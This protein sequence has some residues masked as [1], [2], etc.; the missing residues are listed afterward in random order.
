MND[1]LELDL[2]RATAYLQGIPLEQLLSERA[3][4]EAKRDQQPEI[5]YRNGTM[6]QDGQR[7]TDEQVAMHD[8]RNPYK[9]ENWLSDRALTS[10]QQSEDEKFQEGIRQ[11]EAARRDAMIA[12]EGQSFG[13][14]IRGSGAPVRGIKLEQ[15]SVEAIPAKTAIPYNQA[16]G[17][18][19]PLKNVIRGVA[20]RTAK[21]RKTQ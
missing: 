20:S 2:A 14:I 5:E 12:S 15:T 11:R 17:A 19:S 6:F 3:A 21:P 10:E 18:K 13:P 16:A 9:S 4:I 8:S 1:D 7:A